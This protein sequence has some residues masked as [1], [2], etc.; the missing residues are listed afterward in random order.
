MSMSLEDGLRCNLLYGFLGPI[1]H[2]SF[3]LVTVEPGAEAE[4][5][6]SKLKQIR[7][8]IKQNLF[9]HELVWIDLTDDKIQ[10]LFV[11]ALNS[12]IQKRVKCALDARE[13]LES[14]A[15]CISS[16]A[17]LSATM[18]KHRNRGILSSVTE[19]VSQV[20]RSF[21]SKP[22]NREDLFVGEYLDEGGDF[23]L[24]QEPKTIAR[25]TVKL[26]KKWKKHPSLLLEKESEQW[27]LR[28][29][30]ALLAR[31]KEPEIL[32]ILAA[33]DKE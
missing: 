14:V 28:R 26:L 12:S 33:E 17:M 10:G 27:W 32:A 30:Q 7:S 13:A 31:A 20:G 19:K 9:P 29:M 5:A 3:N 25:D 21:F 15:S 16:M 24:V 6:A 18:E 23:V 8:F 11:E 2:L 22:S 1:S 4:R